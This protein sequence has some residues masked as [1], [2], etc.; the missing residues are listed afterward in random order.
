MAAVFGEQRLHLDGVSLP[1]RMLFRA[2]GV[3]DPAHYLH[4][5]YFTRALDRWPAFA[6]REILDAGC[7][8][9][10]YTFYLARRYPGARVLGV[11]MDQA[12]IDRNRLMAKRL[13]IGNAEF[14]LADLVGHDFG[15]RFDLVISVDV[16]EHI[17]AQEEALRNL[18]RHLSDDGRVFFHVPTVRERPVPFSGL[19]A[20]FHAW[21]E[22][23]H[24]AE[25]RSATEFVGVMRRAGFEITSTHRTF[26]YFT[27]ELATSLFMLPYRKTLFNQVMQAALAPVCRVLSWL[28]LLGLERTRY[29]V[30]VTARRRGSD[31]RSASPDALSSRGAA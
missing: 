2:M 21:A 17:V 19:L 16:L 18:L 3:A 22:D 7:G 31:A 26:G 28:D 25:E 15:R 24:L 27:G 12:R 10:D 23:E 20:G 14:E 8:R 6:P 11:D 30:A 1:E 13:G 5:L 4:S 9:G 29:A